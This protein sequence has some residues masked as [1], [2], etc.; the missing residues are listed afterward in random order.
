MPISKN[1]KSVGSNLARVRIP[2][3]AP[4]TSITYKQSS[5]ALQHTQRSYL[6]CA[7]YFGWICEAKSHHTRDHLA[8]SAVFLNLISCRSF[9]NL[10]L[11]TKVAQRI[12]PYTSFSYTF[13]ILREFT[14]P[15]SQ[16]RSENVQVFHES[17]VSFN[18]YVHGPRP[19]DLFSGAIVARRSV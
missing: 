9:S 12:S 2:P 18:T 13:T 10:Q 1:L 17:R 19:S 5:F 14:K 6:R 15:T 7:A 3:S 11:K 8:P 16:F 4:I